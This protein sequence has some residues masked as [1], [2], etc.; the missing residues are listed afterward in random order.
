LFKG[1]VFH[2]AESWKELFKSVFGC[3]NWKFLKNLKF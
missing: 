3:G 2:L 1:A